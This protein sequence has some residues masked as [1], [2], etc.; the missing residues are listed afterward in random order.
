MLLSHLVHSDLRMS[1]SPPTLH[2]TFRL[3]TI[4]P[5]HPIT[6]HPTPPSLPPSALSGFTPAQR[7]AFERTVDEI[8]DQFKSVVAEGRSVQPWRVERLAQG[9]VWPG[10]DALRLGIVDEIGGYCAAL[11]DA[12]G[13][14]L[15]AL[16]AAGAPGAAV[17]DVRIRAYPGARSPVGE[18]LQGREE[19]GIERD[20]G[21]GTPRERRE[22]KRAA[23]GWLGWGERVLGAAW[24]VGVVL[25][26]VSEVEVGGV[27]CGAAGLADVAAG[28][29]GAVAAWAAGAAGVA[30]SGAGDVDPV[31]RGERWE[32]VCV[33]A[34]AYT[35]CQ[36]HLPYYLPHIALSTF[37]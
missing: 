3:P 5:C 1:S 27:R 22:E 11:E 8:Y 16:R 17:S 2:P 34:T 19:G 9:R 35:R 29:V 7:R 36:L 23:K 21:R 28:A 31:M 26:I 12:R 33:S 37:V 13:R 25:G 10:R 18:L 20:L 30:G 14:A 24:A 15:A 32:C 4:P 6:P